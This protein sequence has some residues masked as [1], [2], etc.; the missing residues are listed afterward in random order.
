[1]PREGKKIP[2]EL[3]RGL[4][5]KSAEAH[6]IPIA[7]VEQEIID[8]LITQLP[9]A[10]NSAHLS[11]WCNSRVQ[12]ILEEYPDHRNQSAQVKLDVGKELQ[13][14]LDRTRFEALKQKI[15][16]EGPETLNPAWIRERDY[17]LSLSIRRYYK[18]I[19]GDVDWDFIARKLGVEDK[20]VA[21]EKIEWKKEKRD[22][23]DALRDLLESEDPK[24]FSPNW[25]FGHPTMSKLYAQIREHY[26][27][28]KNGIDWPT[29]LDKLGEKWRKRFTYVESKRGL[30]LKQH[31]A[32]ILKVLEKEKPREFGPW[33]LRNNSHSDY[34]W[35]W[36]NVR[37]PDDSGINWS[38]V[39]SLLPT[40][41]Q[42]RWEKQYKY[43]EKKPAESFHDEESVNQALGELRDKF[44]T[45][46]WHETEKDEEDRDKI[47]D[48]LTT[49][50]QSG[51]SYA[52]KLLTDMLPEVIHAW[53]DS[54]PSLQPLAVA[55]DVMQ[56]V[57]E[58]CI[59][60]YRHKKGHG[61]FL[62]YLKA[63]LK[64]ALKKVRAVDM[65]HKEFRAPELLAE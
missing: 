18:T 34:D 20:F 44:Y 1:M 19:D 26:T 52:H 14:F 46:Y 32:E 37:L 49:A 58:R 41:W 45:L 28:E 36:A 23:L 47:Y 43:R 17:G 6:E 65:E 3:V 48:I 63:S 33:W 2:P 7:K 53:I 61:G 8:R 5:E 10:P 55:S 12:K 42:E 35:F 64:F 30:D 50:A 16:E 31:I 13:Y 57:I 15:I 38:L 27:I 56:E 22:P 51:N 25:I 59:I 62:R 4:I 39:I 60:L 11:R 9:E 40:E 54:Y 24:T 21:R 29:V